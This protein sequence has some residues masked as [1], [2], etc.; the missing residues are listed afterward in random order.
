MAAPT[1]RL[2][3]GRPSLCADVP[4]TGAA[5]AAAET[6]LPTACDANDDDDGGRPPGSP[7]KRGGAF[8][9]TGDLM[10]YF[11]GT[12]SL[13]F[14]D[15]SPASPAADNSDAVT[16]ITEET[17]ERGDEIWNALTKS[18]GQTMPTDWK[19]SRTRSLHAPASNPE[20]MASRRTS[21]VAADASEAEELREQLDMHSIIVS[22]LGEEP[23]FTA[24]QVIEELEEMM[25]D[26]PDLEAERDPSQSDSSRISLD[27]QRPGR[28]RSYEERVCRLNVAA[29]NERLEA[30]E[31][32]V[33]RLSEEL[34]QH[35]A[36]RDELDFEKEVKNTFIS[37]LIDLQNRQKERG[38]AL[39][40]KKK[41]KLKGAAAMS[42]GRADK[43]LGSRFSVEGLSSVIQNSF[44]QTFGSARSERQ[45]LTT[46]IP[47]ENKGRPPS[48][49]ELQILI[50]IL[51][52]MRDDSDKVPALLT[53][54]ILK[55]VV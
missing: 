2:D 18:Y 17:L 50:K 23:L 51:H 49:E 13:C 15:G 42:Q 46:V 33:R 5:A 36:L 10:D 27:A 47:Y 7:G 19:H 29:L 6:L 28:S 3:D 9:S 4:P 16:A 26:S 25:Q 41:K 32:A 44:R 40:K 8:A 12:L 54:Y 30:T 35:L 55:A 45:Y 34:V 37:A 11:D 20:E 39:K 48:V 14:G 22:C 31:L 53:D 1:A 43:P 52:A 24:E 38:E 21:D